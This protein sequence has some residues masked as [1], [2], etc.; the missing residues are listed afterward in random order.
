MTMKTRCAILYK[1]RELV[2]AHKDELA[3]VFGERE[4]DVNHAVSV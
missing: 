2:L 3:Q 4:R 1:F